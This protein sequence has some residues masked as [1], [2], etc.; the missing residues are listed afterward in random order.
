V[1]GI[2]FHRFCI[3][4]DLIIRG[5]SVKNYMDVF[6]VIKTRRSVRA[7]KPDA[8]PEE[9]LKKVLEAARLAPSAKNAQSWKFIVVQDEK[10]RKELA[11]AAAN[12]TFVGEAPVVIAAV[13]L[14]PNYIM[15]CGVPAYAVDLSIAVDHMTLVAVEEGLGTCWIGGFDQE[16][17]REILKIP[18]KYKVVALLPIGFPADSP[19]PKIRKS[20]EEIVCYDNFLQ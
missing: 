19:G 17:V 11:E 13:A 18:S 4:A 6:Q 1:L 16:K 15:S 9:S 8:I 7:Y 14:E 2:F 10:K 12:Q 20:F 5:I 3:Y